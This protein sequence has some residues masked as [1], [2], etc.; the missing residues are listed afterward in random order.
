VGAGDPCDDAL[1]CTTG[2][3]IPGVG[4]EVGGGACAIE[5]AC[6]ASGA[7]S[8]DDVCG[9][10]DPAADPRAWSP[11]G[12]V[13]CEDTDDC[14]TE[15][16]CQGAA[17]AGTPYSCEDGLDCTDDA[18]DGRGGCT[19]QLRPEQCLIAGQCQ[20][21]G[22]P[23][24]QNPCEG[25]DPARSSQAWVADDAA[26]PAD[27]GIPCTQD[28]CAGGQ[29]VH[30]PDDARCNG[31]EVCATCA[32]GCAPLPTLDV[33]YAGSVEA[34]G[35]AA[36]CTVTD[37][38]DLA[39]LECGALVGMTSLVRE[40]FSGC[41][42]LEDLGWTVGANPPDCWSDELYLWLGET[43]TF[44]RTVDT[45]DFD[46]VRLCFE[47][48]EDSP[49][50][51]DSLTVEIDA[52]A[53]WVEVWSDPGAPV[54]GYSTYLPRCVDLDTVVP[55]AADNASLEIRFTMEGGNLGL[56]ATWLDT[57]AVDAWHD[58][59]LSWPG[60]V[61]SDDFGGCDLGGWNAG[62][63]AP[64]CPITTG[65]LQGEE[66]LEANG[67]T[68]EI[69]R[70]VDLSDRCEDVVVGLSHAW[71]AGGSGDGRARL[72][73]DDGGGEQRAWTHRAG[74]DSLE[75][76]QEFVVNLSHRKPDLRFDP[77]VDVRIEADAAGVAG[78]YVWLDDVWVDGAVCE[79][80]AGLIGVGAPVAAGVGEATVS[81]DSP[82]Q[83]S[84]FLECTWA[85][86]PAT[87]ARDRIVFE[88]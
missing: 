61:V 41:P 80:G 79:S 66:A 82:V 83:A 65:G 44:S 85:G 86:R 74:A 15:D 68:W 57:V 37:V 31:T 32:G 25:C 7:P 20:A 49:G 51:A 53:G 10:C 77:D 22:D 12:V 34:P 29:A 73:Y 27:D 18:C 50:V 42:R 45:S 4:C 55:A 5:G 52:G 48:A 16:E 84:V 23:N 67:V 72:Y 64:A 26:V 30:T 87:L 70:S 39:C 38:A 81:V 69:S 58:S 47:Q 8:P 6:W 78:T 17:C 21:D 35:D 88:N 62:A 2:V 9:V 75:Q 59:Y 14:T 63:G 3:C 24:P 40:T 28:T 13:S 60:P 43:A 19:S 71:L 36:T 11:S 76:L 54:W 33:D 1:D 56:Q 46:R